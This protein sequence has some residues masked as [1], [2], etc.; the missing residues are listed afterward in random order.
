[1]RAIRAHAFGPPSLLRPEEAPDPQIGP[2]DVLVRVMAAAANF[3]DALI[4]RGL[5]QVKPALPFSPGAEFAGVVEAVGAE[6]SA[7]RAGDRVCGSQVCGAFAERVGA[8]AAMVFRIPPSMSFEEA[9]VFRVGNGTAYHALV[10]RARLAAGERVLVLG[11]GGAVGGAAVGIAKALG[12]FVVASG[13]SSER[14]SLALEAGADAVFDLGAADWRGAARALNEGRPFDVVVDPLG[15]AFTEPAF[16]SLAWGGR[17]LVI[18]FAAGPIPALP[19]NLALVKGAALLGVDFRQFNLL[20][21]D[22]AARNMEALFEL[23]AAKR[24]AAQPRRV[25]PAEEAGQALED[26]ASGAVLGRRV[27][28]FSA[29]S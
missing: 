1:M 18:G 3:V 23:F 5:Y 24:L 17:H 21:P 22:A 13:A 26:A 8:P 19:T 25:Y 27:V 28:D 12:A 11:A 16:R 2:S 9:A 6:V 20:E 10:Q 15:G 29:W 14:R 4:V 7:L